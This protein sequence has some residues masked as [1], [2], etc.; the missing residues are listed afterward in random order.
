MLVK[1]VHH[2]IKNNL[3]G[4]AGL[5]Q[6]T[7]RAGPRWPMLISEAVGQVQAIA[8]VYGLQV[9]VGGPLRVKPLVEAITAVG[10]A[11]LRSPASVIVTWRHAGAPL[12][13]ARGRIDPDRADVNELLTNA[14]KHSGR[15]TCTACCTAWRRRVD[16]DPSP[17][18]LPPGFRPGAGAAWRVGPGPGA[19][20]AAAAHRHAH[21][22]AAGRRGRGAVVLRAAQRGAAAEPL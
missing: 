11:H 12:A 16:P 3:Q 20:A 1:E 9:G 7:R 22:G 18:Q 15:A 13:A 5:L 2:R 4:V 21:A 17:G 10:A 8:Q 14:I 19:R 6:Q